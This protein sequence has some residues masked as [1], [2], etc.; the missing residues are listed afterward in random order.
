MSA[1]QGAGVLTQ[2]YAPLLLY[3]GTGLSV[4]PSTA[5]AFLNIG[6]SISVPRNGILVISIA[7][8]VSGGAG[9]IQLKITRGGAT[10]KFGSIMGSL[11]TDQGLVYT[12]TGAT[13]ANETSIVSTSAGII[14][15]ELPRIQFTAG[16]AGVF[17]AGGGVRELIPLLAGDT[18]QFIATNN[19]AGATTYIDDL[20]VMLI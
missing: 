14:S 7:A 6:P 1:P 17:N 13:Y 3:H 8:H 5:G 10:Y 2:T 19:T 4:T 20:V 18:L 12:S 9:Q 15:E 11:V 16:T